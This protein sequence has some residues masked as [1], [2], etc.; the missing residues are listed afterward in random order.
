MERLHARNVKPTGRL[1]WVKLAYRIDRR[2]ELLPALPEGYVRLPELPRLPSAYNGTGTH[3]NP[4]CGGRLSSSRGAWGPL[5]AVAAA[6]LYPLDCVLGLATNI[7]REAA[8]LALFPVMMVGQNAAEAVDEARS[9]EK[10]LLRTEPGVDTLP[11]DESIN[12][13]LLKD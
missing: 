3:G 9:G 5:A 4:V 2:P 6:P 11:E 12:E 8:A 1:H 10:V 13:L 7:S